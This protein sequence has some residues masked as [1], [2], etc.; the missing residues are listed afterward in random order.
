VADVSSATSPSHSALDGLRAMAPII[1]GMAPFGVVAGIAAVEAG[2]GVLGAAAFSSMVFA[3]ASQLAALDL[4]ADGTN[5]LVIVGTIAVINARFLM[6][7]VS[8]AP[9]FADE[10]LGRRAAM[11]YLLTDQAYAVT[12]TR[13]DH[14]PPLRHRWAFFMG[15]AAALWASWQVFTV[16]GAV[17]GAVVPTGLPLGFA[18]PLV[19]TALLVPAVTDRPTLVAACVSAVVAVVAGG[20]PANTGLLVA[21][22][23]GIAAGLV[24]SLTRERSAART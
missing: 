10:P 6:Y 22:V 5:P 19:F 9:R 12:I 11:A 24:V 8:L 21:A 15:G 1:L 7:A 17:A 4:L 13:L 20:L 14:G 16:L 18:I 3:G 23:S 2:V